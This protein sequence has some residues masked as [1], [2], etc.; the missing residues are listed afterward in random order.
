[1]VS[2]FSLIINFM[3]SLEKPANGNVKTANS[4]TCT[5]PDNGPQEIADINFIFILSY[6]VKLWKVFGERFSKIP[7]HNEN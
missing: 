1:M 7:Q 4:F 5:E 6:V 2:P 3:K